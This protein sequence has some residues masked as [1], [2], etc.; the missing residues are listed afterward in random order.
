[1]AIVIV[2]GP[3]PPILE[4]L[5]GQL[6]ELGISDVRIVPPDLRQIADVAREADGG[7]VLLHGDIATNTEALAGLIADPRI[8]TGVLVA[9]G[10]RPG[11][12]PLRTRGTS[13]ASA[14]SEAH[15]VTDP[16]AVFLGV[17]KVG[18]GQREL[19]V[20]TAA[21]VAPL[22]SDVL[23]LLV[24]GLVR[25]G[26]PMRTASLR[27][28][29]WERPGT[30]TTVAEAAQVDEDRVLLDSAVKGADG[31]FTTFFVSP[32]SRFL[33]RWAARRGFTP[34][35]VTAVSFLVGILAA[36]CFA[37]GERWGLVAGAILLQVAFTTDCVD[38]QLA[39]YTRQFSQLGAWLDASFDRAKEYVVFAGLAIGADSAG[40][41]VWVLAASAL[42]LQ[43]V[44]HAMDF[45]WHGARR[46][47]IQAPTFPPLEERKDGLP[48]VRPGKG[49]LARWRS[50]D[51]T[52]GVVWVKRVI[53]FPIGE[54]FALI[55]ITAA[56]W[57]AR[58]TFIAWLA[59]AGFAVTYGLVGRL[60]R[61]AKLKRRAEPDP[62]RE[63]ESFRD[64][65]PIA[66]AIGP[67]GETLEPVALCVVAVA[68]LIAAIAIKG[69][70][71]SDSLALPVLGWLVIVAGLSSGRTGTSR[72]RWLV[73]PLLRLGEYAGLLWVGT[74]AGVS[75]EPAA[76][77]L[78][79]A[80]TI[81]H[82]DLVYGLRYRGAQV[83]ERLGVL[84]GGWDGRLLLA[85]ALLAAAALPAG[86]YV[87]AA[88]VAVVFSAAAIQGW[89]RARMPVAFEDDKED[90]D[91]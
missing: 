17:L 29:V 44:R 33:A 67:L 38:G 65:G 47:L 34:N 11:A 62:Q 25:S 46:A 54:R 19:L 2:D 22:G 27:G 61:S 37:T 85:G 58:T 24:V 1:M 83:P 6:N 20:D 3:R 71:A 7:V 60:V 39:R 50:L 70:A 73:P 28:M 30:D 45:S 57:S 13:V 5:L 82:Y 32:Y 59:W 56:F 35:Q 66:R 16:N 18:P 72:L 90:E 53:A 91:T 12:A 42:T 14:G 51:E 63:L 4:R 55:S 8:V 36:A 75:S 23:E 43:V 64:D 26:V 9:R 40:D 76:F 21:R 78:L 86:L 77:A 80:L 41:P 49:A 15:K 48:R 87:L 84:M 52:P 31:F 81:R 88:L 10:A 69:D 89:S 79:A 74:L 68:P